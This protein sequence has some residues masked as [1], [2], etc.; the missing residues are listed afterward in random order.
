MAR[1]GD[2]RVE[3]A[4]KQRA[5]DSA[6]LAVAVT[7]LAVGF[8]GG[9]PGRGLGLL[10]LLSVSSEYT[11]RSV[12]TTEI[13]DGAADDTDLVTFDPEQRARDGGVNA[14][15]SYRRMEPDD[16]RPVTESDRY[17]TLGAVVA[18]MG[19]DL[20]LPAVTTV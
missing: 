5:V 19:R 3:T 11:L 15:T 9:I 17:A 7:T 6:L 10:V 20:I 12:V 2:G 16:E 14:E 1:N 18:A 4:R 8:A 13:V